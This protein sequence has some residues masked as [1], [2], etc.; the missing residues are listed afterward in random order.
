MGTISAAIFTSSN[1]LPVYIPTHNKFECTPYEDLT[2]REVI[3]E[4]F[5]V[6]L[7]TW[8]LKVPLII[9]DIVEMHEID[10]VLR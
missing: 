4:E 5:F 7:N 9:Y 1:E 8:H 2:I 10:R 6:N 3:L